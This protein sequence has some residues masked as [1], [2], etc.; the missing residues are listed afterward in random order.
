MIHTLFVEYEYEI[1]KASL[2][3]NQSIQDLNITVTQQSA[4][5]IKNVEQYNLS[6]RR[7][8]DIFASFPFGIELSCRNA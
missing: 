5:L 2:E 6:N 1:C 8:F 4:A 7:N 3:K